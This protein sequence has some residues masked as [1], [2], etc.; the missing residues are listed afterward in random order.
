LRLKK[1]ILGPL[2]FAWR[3]VDLLA[4]RLEEK[5]LGAP[6]LPEILRQP[7]A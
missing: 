5:A 7:I 1:D 3:A 2:E 6:G 4:R